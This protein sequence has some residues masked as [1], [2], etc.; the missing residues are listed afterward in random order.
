M[1]DM[2][3]IP[4]KVQGEIHKIFPEIPERKIPEFGRKIPELLGILIESGTMTREYRGPLPP[5]EML[6]GYDKVVNGSAERIIKMVE[7]QSEHRKAMQKRVIYYGTFDSRIGM[8]LGFFLALV[9]ILGGF[10]L[11][12]QGKNIY[13]LSAII[14]AIASLIS[15]FIYGKYKESSDNKRI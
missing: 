4:P 3:K 10:L 7:E 8:F 12:Y 2:L 15:V 1:D 5:P 14:I 9:I 13:G 6:A 11:M